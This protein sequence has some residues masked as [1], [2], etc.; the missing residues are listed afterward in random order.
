MNSIVKRTKSVGLA[1][2][3][4]GCSGGNIPPHGWETHIP[5]VYVGNQSGFKEVIAFNRDNTF[6]HAVYHGT[7][8][9]HSG[10]GEWRVDSGE[11]H[12]RLSEFVEFYNAMD[13]SFSPAPKQFSSYVFFVVS[14]AAG[15]DKMSANV[16]LR[17]CLTR[18]M[19]GV[20]NP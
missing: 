7:N 6:T 8:Q 3:F 18:T 12:I 17:Y 10:T 13:D 15:F 5:G 2:A 20:G 19:D 4:C 16:D 9:L 11:K 1:I 14:N